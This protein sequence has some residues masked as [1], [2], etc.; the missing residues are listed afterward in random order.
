MKTAKIQI[1]GLILLLILT[2][3]YN[4]IYSHGGAGAVISG[5]IL[6]QNEDVINYATIHLKGTEH[7]VGTDLDGVYHL[8]VPAGKYT[9]VVTAVGYATVERDIEL[10]PGMRSKLN[11]KLS[12]REK[13]LEEVTVV[14]NG[15]S[16]VNRSAYN[17][18]AIDTKSLQNSTQ[19]LGEALGRAPGMKIRESGGVGSDMQLMMDGFTGR[20]IKVFIDGIPQEGVG[21][22]FGLNN[23]P[24]NYADRIE[25]YR[26]VVPVGFGSDALGGVINVVTKKTSDKRWYVDAS[27]SYGSFN[28]HKSYVN[29]G[30]T[31]KNGFTY[32]INA[33]Q[34]YSDNDYKVKTF[35]KKFNEDGTTEIDRS[36]IVEVKRFHDNYHNES[37]IGKVGFVNKAWAD[38]FMLGFNYSRMYNEI[39]TGVR[40]HTVFGEKF[41]D[42]Y[43]LMPSLEYGKR[44]L[45]TKGLD[46]VLTANYNKNIINDVDT[47]SYEYNWYG[48][49]VPLKSGVHGEYLAK[50][51]RSDNS[52]WNGTLTTN[53]R[54]G[55]KHTFTFNHVLNSFQ[56]TTKSKL[57]GGSGKNPIPS[58]NR[59]NVGGLSY[60]LMP[61]EKWNLS[62]F[63][64]YYSQYISGPIATNTNQ[65]DYV[66][67]SRT[68]NSFGYGAAGTYYILDELQA[69]LSYEKAHRL[70]TER[71]LF[72]DNDLNSGDINLKSENSHNYNLNLSYTNSFG[73]HSLYV[74]GGVLF[75]YAEN[76]IQRK[77]ESMGSSREGGV[78]ENHGRVKTEGFNLS[79]RYGFGNWLSLGGNFTQMNVR[80]NVKTNSST[81]AQESTTYGARMPNT[82]YQFANSDVTFYWRNL[83]DKGNLLTVTY[84][85][86]Y[87]HSFPFRSEINGRHDKQKVPTQFSHNLSIT[88]A[89]QN[90]RYNFSFECKNFTDETVYD[91]FMLQKAGRAFYGKFRVYFGK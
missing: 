33:F 10:K 39:Q 64:K 45:L 11:F 55:H 71:E 52:N 60:R 74:E 8:K 6:S 28:T 72:G 48:Q 46:V 91:N 78:F 21:K 26:G 61:S 58:V 70:P 41:N 75:R 81:S 69:K 14:S 19:N 12:L 35:V 50:L 54:F 59:K 23:I 76:Y 32:E 18:V 2:L 25:V 3:C 67:T 31:L 73:Q 86:I 29:F 56:K 42:G 1:S 17:A 89:I 68:V 16:R 43:S 90:G 27:Y 51:D 44:N 65:D 79:L 20:H 66:R 37:V 80:D 13:A 9:L 15:V 7:G 34:N 82:P 5:K 30:Q 47:A 40:Q 4:P 49:R 63:G 83:F 24:V 36:K 77:I 53:Y 84:D 88:Y 87:F 22:S 38:R 85:N 57:G 62:V